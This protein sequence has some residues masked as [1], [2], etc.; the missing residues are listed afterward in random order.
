MMIKNKWQAAVAESLNIF[1]SR[2]ADTYTATSSEITASTGI[3]FRESESVRAHTHTH[4]HTHTG[5]QRRNTHAQ[6]QPPQFNAGTQS[7]R[8]NMKRD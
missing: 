5:R 2:R 8:T 6:A 7:L 3:E 1:L 4:T